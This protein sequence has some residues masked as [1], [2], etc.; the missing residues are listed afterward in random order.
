MGDVTIVP[1]QDSEGRPGSPAGTAGV[2]EGTTCFSSSSK[3]SFLFPLPNQIRLGSLCIA[4]ITDGDAA[5]I[6]KRPP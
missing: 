5:R 1:P 2:A 6:N 3:F 4:C